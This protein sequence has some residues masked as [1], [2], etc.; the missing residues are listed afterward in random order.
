MS[1]ETLDLVDSTNEAAPGS[2][3]ET[4]TYL[5]I[6]NAAGDRTYA[7]RAEHSLLI[8]RDPACELRIDE[9]SV[10]RKHAKLTVVE[11]RAH[12]ADLDSQNGTVLGDTR[13][14]GRAQLQPGDVFYIGGSTFIFHE[15]HA[16]GAWNEHL[17]PCPNVRA[18]AADPKTRLFC[19][20]LENTARSA[21]NVLLQGETGT[22]KEVAARALHFS[23]D[24]RLAPIIA[25]NC[26]ALPEALIESELFGH[27]RGAFSGAHATQTGLFEEAHGGT[28]FLDE[29]GELSLPAQAK[30]LRVLETRRVSRLGEGSRERTLDLR[31][32]AASNR[33]LADEVAQG[34]F[35]RD[36]YF[37]LAGAKLW[38]PALR[39]R[40]ADVPVLAYSFLDE[41]RQQLGRE[42]VSIG[43]RAMALLLEQSWPGNVRQ[44]RHLMELCAA[45][46]EGTTLCP[47]ELQ[48]RL[49]PTPM[50]PRSAPGFRPLEDEVRELEKSRMSAALSA[51][52]GNQKR[53]AELISMPRRTFLTKLKTYGLERFR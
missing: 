51:T 45:N 12:L 15:P 21:L 46:A 18:V 14:T 10:S 26:A 42:A 38:L 47:R 40:R 29:V 19:R 44:L 4:V 2:A 52:Q 43:A 8:G 23:S 35:R 28:I 24:R 7:L 34:R 30:L 49:E 11:G 16:L 1:T 17:L 13:L 3:E 32:I 27:E 5:T 53:A 48:A 22:G 37:R 39:D 33:D 41:A 50:S 36:L 6:H 31:V 25:V 20:E 9:P